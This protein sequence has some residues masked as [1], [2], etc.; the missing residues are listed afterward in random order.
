MIKEMFVSSTPHE[1]K[2][3]ITEDDQLAEIF[4]EREN[5][6]TLAGSI[7]KG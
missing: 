2:V 1:T 3:A 6:Y 4:Y 5:E 7:Y